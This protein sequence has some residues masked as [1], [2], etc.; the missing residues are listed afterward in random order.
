MNKIINFGEI[1]IANL[2]SKFENDPEK[3]SDVLIIQNQILLHID[4][5]STI[6]I[7]LTDRLIDDTY[8][9]RIRIPAS[10]NFEKDCD[11]LMDKIRSIN[12]ERLIIGPIAIL[13]KNFMKE[14]QIAVMQLIGFNRN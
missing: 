13:D 1:W 5:P 2:N 6:V 8:P 11:L 10:N 9:L 3:T 12:N 4:H 14:I 7:P